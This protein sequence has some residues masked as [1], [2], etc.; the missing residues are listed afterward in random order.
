MISIFLLVSE[1]SIYVIP[2]MKKLWMGAVFGCF[3]PAPLKGGF[4]FFDWRTGRLVLCALGGAF[5]F[6]RGGG[7]FG[8]TAAGA[9]SC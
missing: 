3:S 1:T 9:F 7:F 2:G 5:S 8:Y 4:L 6:A